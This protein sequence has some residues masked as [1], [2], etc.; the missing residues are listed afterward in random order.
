[1]NGK[2]LIKNIRNLHSNIAND[3][4]G[5]GNRLVTCRICGNQKEVNPACCLSDGW[6]KCCGYT[7]TIDKIK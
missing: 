3:I 2:R 6:P 4:W 1:M 5:P 7:M